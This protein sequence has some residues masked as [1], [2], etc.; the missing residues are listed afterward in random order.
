MGKLLEAKNLSVKF[1]KSD[2]T[3]RPLDFEINDGE[4]VAIIGES[5]SGK[6]TLLKA[7]SCLSDNDAVICGEV[8][9][10]GVSLVGMK[11]QELRKYRFSSFSMV[12]QNSNEYLNPRLTLKE[13]LSEILIKKY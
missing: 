1:R 4:T 7:L 11:E 5:G 9:F 6:T 3:L 10:K 8:K 13:S 12:F 2:F